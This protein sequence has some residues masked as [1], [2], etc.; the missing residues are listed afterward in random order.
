MKVRSG[1]VSNSSSSS[2][3]ILGYKM[4]TDELKKKFGI[5]ESDEYWDK[6]DELRGKTGLDFLSLD[7]YELVGKLIAEIDSDMGEIGEAEFTGE[8][9]KKITEEI[10]TKL[11]VTDKEPHIFTGTRAT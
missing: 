10:K 4:T 6:V 1:F 7:N 5:K 9:L 2:F 3:V 8:D 11:E